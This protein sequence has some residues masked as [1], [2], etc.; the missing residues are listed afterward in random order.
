ML[1]VLS[2]GPDEH[3]EPGEPRRIDLLDSNESAPHVELKQ[4]GLS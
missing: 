3:L 4:V 2:P 1:S